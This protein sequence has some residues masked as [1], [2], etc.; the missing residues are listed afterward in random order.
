V[1]GDALCA[2]N[3]IYGHGITVAALQSLDLRAALTSTPPADLGHR[4]LRRITRRAALPWSIATGEDC[5]YPTCDGRLGL[6]R[7]QLGRYTHALDGLCAHGDAHARRATAA[8]YHLMAPPTR[9]LHPRLLAATTR[10]TLLG[11][12]DPVA[13]PAALSAPRTRTTSTT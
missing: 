6:V 9:L 2:F 10:A 11:H 5:R 1:L 12:A 4:L 8:V 7:T 3:P 13:R